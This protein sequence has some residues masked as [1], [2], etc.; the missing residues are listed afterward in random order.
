MPRHSSLKNIK[1]IRHLSLD[2]DSKPSLR[3]AMSMDE[4]EGWWLSR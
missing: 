4:G 1:N 2:D 3:L